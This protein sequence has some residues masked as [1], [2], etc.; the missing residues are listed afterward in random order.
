MLIFRFFRIGL[1][2]LI[3]KKYI[4]FLILSNAAALYPP[5]SEMLLSL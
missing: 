2:T 5:L 3:L 1:H 4:F